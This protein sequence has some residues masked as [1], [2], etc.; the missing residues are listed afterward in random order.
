M[1]FLSIIFII[2]AFTS[3]EIINPD[4]EIPAYITIDKIN[5]SS[6][7]NAIGIN[8][9]WVYI[10]GNLQGVY[11]LPAE[12]P[13]L[14]KG[15]REIKIYAGI[16]VN[17]IAATRSWYPFYTPY[18]VQRTII[19]QD[20]IVLNPI[21]S[22]ED[23]VYSMWEEDF[24][25][26]GISIDTAPS[27][28]TNVVF[29]SDDVYAG[30]YS[31]AIILEPGDSYFEGVTSNHF[32]DLPKNSNPVFLEMNYKTDIEFFIGMYIIENNSLDSRSLIMVNRSEEWNK[33]YI[34][35]ANSLNDYQN[36]I[37]FYYY[38]LVYKNPEDTTQS[39]VLLDNIRIVLSQQ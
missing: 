6:E 29:I 33:I 26:I 17:G 1:R 35:L 8:D 32:P 30:N 7:P 21:V 16:K 9:A 5:L 27:S 25:N 28:D 10:D 15:E 23:N 12:F 20:N 38:I 37:S 19:D 34:D 14:E 11:E 18:V 3:C 13:V 39:T 36:A 4:E 31:G 22:Y 24:E 2:V